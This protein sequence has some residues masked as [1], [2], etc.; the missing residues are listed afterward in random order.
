MSLRLEQYHALH[1]TREFLR[2]LLT[3]DRYPRTKAEMRERACRCLKHYPFLREN[4]E[5]MFSQDNFGLET[6]NEKHHADG[7]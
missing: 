1:R 2:D 7:K 6:R 4:G 3:V 5:P